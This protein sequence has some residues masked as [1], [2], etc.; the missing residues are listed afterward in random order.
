[1]FYHQAGFCYYGIILKLK[2]SWLYL[3][4][5]VS[6]LISVIGI[7][8][9]TSSPP[10]DPDSV[11]SPNQPPQTTPDQS[12]GYAVYINDMTEMVNNLAKSDCS[13]FLSLD[14]SDL[15]EDLL[16]PE[17]K[18]KYHELDSQLAN[19]DN[20]YTRIDQLQQGSS[21]ALQ[22]GK[23][24]L[25]NNLTGNP[26]DDQI[27]A[28][29]AK[30]GTIINDRKDDCL[31]QIDKTHWRQFIIDLAWINLD[32]SCQDL[33]FISSYDEVIDENFTRTMFKGHENEDLYS[34]MFLEIN[35]ALEQLEDPHY[36]I[37]AMMPVLARHLSG[38]PDDPDAIEDDFSLGYYDIK[39]R[40][41]QNRPTGNPV[42]W[43]NLVNDY[44][45][46]LMVA[47]INNIAD[48]MYS[49]IDIDYSIYSCVIRAD[50]ESPDWGD[51]LYDIVGD[52]IEAILANYGL[53]GYMVEYGSLF[54]VFLFEA[55][56]IPS[57]YNQDQ[58]ALRKG[59]YGLYVEDAPEFK[60]IKQDLEA[61]ASERFQVCR[62]KL[63]VKE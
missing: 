28:D 10:Q 43:S 61:I 14:F 51:N 1:M 55:G 30:I 49:D 48:D 47:P 25:S 42:K 60:Q 15:N 57:W 17:M 18:D 44:R 58:S 35:D 27:K 31:K 2:F 26:S 37:E 12:S 3:V 24:I 38:V 62:E 32:M 34:K 22:V 23:D 19:L 63:S 54:E 5:A 40:F 46:A 8:Y 9:I 56:G 20:L 50:I 13:T 53:S 4:I 39:Q 59:V 16:T 36:T 41:C 11:G 21:L 29:F 45:R 33:E 52:D 7:Y 6:I